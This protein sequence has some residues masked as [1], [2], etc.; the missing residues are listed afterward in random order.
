MMK[1]S[2]F[3]LLPALLLVTATGFAA[4]LKLESG[5]WSVGGRFAFPIRYDR[6]GFY[7]ISLREEPEFSYFIFDNFRLVSSIEI[8]GDLRMAQAF[9][10]SS[11]LMTWGSKVGVEYVFESWGD[12]FP[13]IGAK[14][15][16]RVQN[17]DFENMHLLLGIPLG[18]HWALSENVAVSFEVPIEIA[19]S[20][21]NGFEHFEII[22][23]Y[24]GVTAFF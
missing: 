9:R 3:I 15:G 1:R 24:F 17:A 22:P 23:G 11:A 20:P 6:T 13:F 8:G 14:T 21:K 19:F 7:Q 5:T 12:I 2:L 4:P 16:F 10:I 18:I